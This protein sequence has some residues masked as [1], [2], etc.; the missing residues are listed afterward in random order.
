MSSLPGPVVTEV[1]TPAVTSVASTDAG[2]TDFAG[3]VEAALDD[4]P[5]GGDVA[6]QT[7]A[8][9]SEP[10]SDVTASGPYA[11][12]M[13][14]APDAGLTEFVAEST[15]NVG[16]EDE[17]RAQAMKGMSEDG[18]SVVPQIPAADSGDLKATSPLTLPQP[19]AARPTGV[20]TPPSATLEALPD[21]EPAVPAAPTTD[22]DVTPVPPTPN[23]TQGQPPAA[24]P[25]PAVMAAVVASALPAQ[26]G[27]PPSPD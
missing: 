4:S 17:T 13:L 14:I 10:S 9:A 7:D 22:G 20:Q 16:R 8:A 25:A 3:L 26:A 6:A 19:P 21:P 24:S 18:P 27:S 2:L 12:P 11:L 23:Q 1:A 15:G 5:A